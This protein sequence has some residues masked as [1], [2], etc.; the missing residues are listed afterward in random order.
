MDSLGCSVTDRV[1]KGT[2]L[3]P[4]E[5]AIESPTLPCWRCDNSPDTEGHRGE[6]VEPLSCLFVSANG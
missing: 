2:P 5:S 6:S 1:I 4:R 3:S